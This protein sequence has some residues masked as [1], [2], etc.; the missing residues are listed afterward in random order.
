MTLVDQ[1]HARLDAD[2]TDQVLR[3]A[4]ADALEESSDEHLASLADGYRALAVWGRVPFGNSVFP[5][6]EFGWNPDDRWL[7]YIRRD[8][9][10]PVDPELGLLDVILQSPHCLPMSWFQPK[11]SHPDR[12]STF[13][14]RRQ[15][16]DEFAWR[17]TLMDAEKREFYSA[18]ARTQA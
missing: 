2:P 16:E 13:P 9:G 14:T 18:P 8:R 7:G 1:L 15:L 5:R 17:F 12:L 11:I 6:W 4:L 10:E 3:A